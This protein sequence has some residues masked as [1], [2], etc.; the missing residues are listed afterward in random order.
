MQASLKSRD[1][2]PH[3]IDKETEVYGA[4]ETHQRSHRLEE[5][6]LNGSPGLL[7]SKGCLFLL[8][9][10]NIYGGGR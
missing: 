5:T 9:H 2:H 6:G 10:C 7:A 4:Q 1:C 3:F 8:C